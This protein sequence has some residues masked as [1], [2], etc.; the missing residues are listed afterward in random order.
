M[1][2]PT[3]ESKMTARSN[4]AIFEEQ[5]YYLQKQ[6]HFEVSF[7]KKKDKPLSFRKGPANITSLGGG[8]RNTNNSSY[9]QVNDVNQQVTT[10]SDK[11]STALMPS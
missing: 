10:P 8:F 2:E 11:I 5:N 7:K 3:N 9:W 6:P 4:P 1:T